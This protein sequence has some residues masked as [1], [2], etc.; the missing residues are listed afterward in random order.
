MS[1]R[2]ITTHYCCV[3]Q[4]NYLIEKAIG[5]ES[6]NLNINYLYFLHAI[7]LGKFINFKSSVDFWRELYTRNFLFVDWLFISV[8]IFHNRRIF[9]GGKNL[10]FFQNLLE[11]PATLIPIFKTHHTHTLTKHEFSN[12]INISN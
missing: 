8:Q 11:M 7:F 2:I 12:R 4:T 9:Y 6:T 3:D 1:W 5:K 10:F